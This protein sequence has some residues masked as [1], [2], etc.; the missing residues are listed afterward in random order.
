MYLTRNNHQPTV[1]SLVADKAFSTMR[2]ALLFKVMKKFD[3]D[4]TIIRT[5]E[6]P[7]KKSSA[8]Q[9]IN[10]ELPEM[11]ILEQ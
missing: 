10:K 11:F 7:C 2:W 6:T 8:Q 3:F 9:K 5:I 4:D 1:I